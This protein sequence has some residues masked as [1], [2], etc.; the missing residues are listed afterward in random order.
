MMILLPIAVTFVIRGRSFI[1]LWM[2]PDYAGAS[3]EVLA[4]LALPLMFHAAAHGLGGLM[5]AIGRHK[6]MIPAMLLEAAAN[7]ALSVAL[8]PSLG[9]SG[10]AWG[11]AIPSVVSSVVFWPPYIQRATGVPLQR[12]L[13]MAWLRPA[14]AVVPFGLA[15][16]VV[17]RVWPADSLW[18]FLTQVAACT[19]LAAAGAWFICLT[20]PQRATVTTLVRRRLGRGDT[21]HSA[22]KT[23]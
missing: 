22:T 2:G 21:P 20:P 14:L 19:L 3:G 5:L 7:V 13:I 16:V 12:F 17:E 18:T 4:I 1:A 9:I 8:I 6:P 11:T 15:S 23:A 10:V